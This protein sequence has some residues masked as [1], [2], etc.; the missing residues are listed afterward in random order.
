[1][2]TAGVQQILLL[3]PISKAAI[4]CNHQLRFYTL[5]E[6]TPVFK[7]LKDVAWIGV[8]ENDLALRGL[9]TEGESEERDPRGVVVLVGTEKVIRQLRIGADVK[10]IRV[11]D[12]TEKGCWTRS[13]ANGRQDGR[14]SH[15]LLRPRVLC[16]ILEHALPT[17]PLMRS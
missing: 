13:L 9:A 5:P 3:A 12:E 2:S 15:F 8:D 16:V 6:L 14:T 4:L 17:L 7:R 10:L 1:V 11:Y